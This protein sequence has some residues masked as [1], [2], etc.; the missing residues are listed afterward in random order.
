MM[1]KA[2]RSSSHSHLYLS[3]TYI[4]YNLQID[5]FGAGG[6]RGGDKKKKKQKTLNIQ[7]LYLNLHKFLKFPE[8]TN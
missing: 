6:A 3:V 5:I 4:S 7:T 2:K 1:K 8:F